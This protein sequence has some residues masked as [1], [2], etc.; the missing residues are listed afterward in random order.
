MNELQKEL[1]EQ[2][3]KF[4]AEKIEPF[5]EEDDREETFRME[6]Y[7]GL[8]ELGLAGIPLPEDVGG[9]DLGYEDLCIVL[10][11]ISKSSAPYA[12]TLSVST[13]VQSIINEFA[14]DWQRKTFLPALTS[15]EE[16]AAFCLSESSSGSDAGSLK[17]TAKKV[18]DGYILNGNKMWITSAGVASTYLVMARTGGEGTSGVSAFIVK[19]GTDGL[20]FG[21]KE[22]KMGWRTSPTREV[23]F[24]NCKIPHNHLLGNE[25]EGFKLAMKALNAGRITIGACALGL[26][27]RALKEAVTYALGREQFNQALFEF[28]GLQ[29]MLADMAAEIESSALLVEKASKMH[30]A[31]GCGKLL[32]STCKLKCTDMAMK[33]T[34]DA[35][36]VLG[37]VGYTSEYPVERLM[38]DA[39]VFQIV[40]GTNQI[41][42]VVIAREL[43]K[44]FQS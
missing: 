21:K 2:I 18:D 22:R 8:G 1:V 14:T 37:G 11:E 26:A 31:G 16:I 10:E 19:D 5:M 7:R 28:Q 13:M 12:V 17:T 38:R 32:A 9:A 15:G 23:Y 20:K 4:N 25:G 43:K 36:Q 44:Q 41:Q 3:N 33:V 30:D 42:K 40:E 6:I 29:F 35:V 34:T 39:K 24:E 27:R